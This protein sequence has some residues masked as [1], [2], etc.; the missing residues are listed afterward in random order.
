MASALPDGSVRVPVDQ[1]STR[2]A[3]RLLTWGIPSFPPVLAEQLLAAT[4]RWPLLLRLI[5][6]VLST[7]AADPA[8]LTEAGR[9]VL[10]RLHGA[11]PAALDHLA[12]SVLDL[13]DPQQRARAVRA[14]IGA[15][16]ELLPPGGEQRMME[17]GIFAEDELLAPSLALSLWRS[18]SHLGALEGQSLFQDLVRLSLITEHSE[19]AGRPFSLHD[20]VRDYVRAELG[21]HRLSAVHRVFLDGV[22]SGLPAAS[23]LSSHHPSSGASWW[24]LPGEEH[25]LWDHLIGHLIAAGRPDEA[26][27][28]A[29]D[30]RWAEAR[31]LRSGPGSPYADLSTVGTPR[32]LEQRAAWVQ[33][34]AL[35]SPTEP[36]NAV[37]D[38][39][40]TALSDS[41]PWSPQ[42]AASPPDLSRARLTSRWPL[43]DVRTDTLRRTFPEHEDDPHPGFGPV[44]L[45][46]DGRTVIAGE[47]DG[48]VVVLDVA[49]GRRRGAHKVHRWRPAAL[50][51]SPDG[52]W[53]VTAAH[54]QTARMWSLETGLD[55][56]GTWRL[57][58]GVENAAFSGDGSWFATLVG[59]VWS[60]PDEGVVQLWDSSSGRSL[61]QLP[62]RCTTFA[63]SPSGSWIVTGHLDGRVAIWD[64]ASG[65]R[66][67]D[68]PL[69]Q[70]GRVSALAIS[71]DATWI[72][73]GSDRGTLRVLAAA[74]G[75]LDAELTL[76]DRDDGHRGPAAVTAVAISP[77]GTWLAVGSQAQKVALWTRGTDTWQRT[78]S[79]Q[80]HVHSLVI[81]PDSSWFVVGSREGR[82]EVWE[83]TDAR[84]TE[85]Q[86]PHS[87]SRVA[88]LL[89]PDR[90]RIRTIGDDGVNTWDPVTGSGFNER[91]FRGTALAA[92]PDGR[93]LA[94]ADARRVRLWEAG[95]ATPLINISQDH[96]V[97]ALAIRPDGGLTF[98]SSGGG[99]V[100]LWDART[101]GLLREIPLSA[102]ASP[103]VS[104]DG[105]WLAADD[106]ARVTQIWDLAADRLHG[107]AAVPG[108]PV[109][110]SHDGTRLAIAAE[111]VVRVWDIPSNAAIAELTTAEPLIHR[112]AFSHDGE[113]LAALANNTLS[114]WRLAAPRPIAAT[115]TPRPLVDCVWLADD[116]GIATTGVGGLYVFDL[117]PASR[118]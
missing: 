117:A 15:S 71:P 17:L 53:C 46:P 16:T 69:F 43:P 24:H 38:V 112:A 88:A 95:S 109:G 87:G 41:P 86:T 32:A 62:D 45:S 10:E 20:V 77:D 101:I 94:T 33:V 111:D 75:A 85:V 12:T 116:T 99:R 29:C 11:G 83:A 106:A 108:R 64:A 81:S 4:G 7:A 37:L 79:T 82:P 103:V 14:T 39:L 61:G 78:L 114:V 28:V 63:I 48:H 9:D 67:A 113:H 31:L 42:I 36:R 105:R 19:L 107:E 74:D 80:V 26:E 52:A 100:R 60:Y 21:P 118:P 8:A 40:R 22:S 93:L 97:L 56:P 59:R 2:Q 91:D 73:V 110:F 66:R 25:Y 44:A 115:R 18:T 84:R 102:T 30:L 96:P 35:L 13:D 72:A 92:S 51:V 5:N 98:V 90:A 58:K 3:H 23:A 89:T 50:A 1:M 55:R 47:D 65:E 54:R 6:R 49:T 34:S 68:F 104:V 76:P 57:P 27:R 70:E